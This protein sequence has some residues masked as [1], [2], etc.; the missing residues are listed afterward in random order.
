MSK[1]AEDDDTFIGYKFLPVPLISFIF[2]KL[3]EAF[4][5]EI[6]LYIKDD[7]EFRNLETK[8]L[9]ASLFDDMPKYEI[10]N[11]SDNTYKKMIDSLE[12][13][14]YQ[15]FRLATPPCVHPFYTV[16]KSSFDRHT[17]H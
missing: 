17:Y 6:I 7:K 10:Q 5:P 9:E 12:Q 4:A 15:N 3:G 2:K 8:S 1:L 11:V 13:D 16:L 14:S